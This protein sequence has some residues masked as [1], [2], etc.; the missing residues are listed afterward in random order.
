MRDIQGERER[1]YENPMAKQER[2]EDRATNAKERN[3]KRRRKRRE[4]AHEEKEK[5]GGK[6]VEKG[7]GT[8]YGGEGKRSF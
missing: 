1:E 8:R 6:E 2:E 7:R 4:W 5:Y 3:T